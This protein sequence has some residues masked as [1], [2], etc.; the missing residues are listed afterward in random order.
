M[1]NRKFSY[2]P[3]QIGTSF[4]LLIFVILCMVTFSVLSLSSS[5]KDYELSKKSA[6]RTSEY[7]NAC[8]MAE[9]KLEQI[10][11]QIKNNEISKDIIEFTVPVNDYESLQV[12]L[13]IHPQS[14]PRYSV[15][16]WKQISSQNWSGDET[17]PVLGGN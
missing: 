8:N 13:K 2:P 10:D 1:K 14:S 7:Y 15:I 12:S 5:M 4:M 6:K 11:E 3:L 9:E 16:T 17:L